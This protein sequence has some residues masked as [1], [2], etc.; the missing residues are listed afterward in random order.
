MFFTGFLTMRANALRRGNASRK[1][2]GVTRGIGHAMS[3]LDETRCLWGNLY[4]AVSDS[5]VVEFGTQPGR[6]KVAFNRMQ[7]HGA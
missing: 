6:F 3:R 2:E 1:C 4:S 7:Q 5:Q